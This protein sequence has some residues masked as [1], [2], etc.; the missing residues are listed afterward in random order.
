[1]AFKNY[2]SWAFAWTAGGLKVLKE[3]WKKLGHGLQSYFFY[4]LGVLLPAG[5]TIFIVYK[6]F[7]ILKHF[8]E[9]MYKETLPWWLGVAVTLLFI[10]IVGVAARITLGIRMVNA[11][12]YVFARIPLIKNIFTMIKQLQQLIL[13]RKKMVFEKV[14]LL[15]YPRKGIWSL[16]FMT[17]DATNE[18]NSKTGE[19]LVTVFLST[20]PNPTSGLLIFVPRKDVFDLQMSVEEA[21]KVIISGGLLKPETIIEMEGAQT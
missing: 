20:T 6:L 3:S 7:E 12:E 16:G 11:M 14:V 15:E 9:S 5:I 8:M 10:L 2:K 19:D 18:L 1:M 4:G 13:G 21:F 17:A